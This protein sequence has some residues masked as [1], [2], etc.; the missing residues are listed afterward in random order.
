MISCEGG[1]HFH[2]ILKVTKMSH[3]L[4]DHHA[5]SNKKVLIVMAVAVINTVLEMF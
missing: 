4:R 5:D 3:S 1:Y 2:S